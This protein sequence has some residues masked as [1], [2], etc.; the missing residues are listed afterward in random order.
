MTQIGVSYA[1]AYAV[2]KLFDRG[3]GSNHRGQFAVKAVGQ[4][5]V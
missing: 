5:L 1:G 4:Q 2:F 3:Y